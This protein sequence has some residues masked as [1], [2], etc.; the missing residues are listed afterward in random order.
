MY[1]F[2]LYQQAEGSTSGALGDIDPS[3]SSSSR[4]RA[5]PSTPSVGG[6][7]GRSIRRFRS[8]HPLPPRYQISQLSQVARDRE[9]VPPRYQISQLS[10]LARERERLPP[11]YTLSQLGRERGPARYTISQ[12]ARFR[13]AVLRF[14]ERRP[15]L[16]SRSA[17]STRNGRGIT[18]ASSGM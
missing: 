2:S 18:T 5:S 10:Q 15:N 17:P 13:P 9:R 16:F 7:G 4:R 3:P 6:V 1:F 14:S 8:N 11:R 12:L